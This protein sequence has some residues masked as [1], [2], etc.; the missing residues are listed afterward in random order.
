LAY[1]NARWSVS[2]D[3]HVIRSIVRAKI[4][5][6]KQVKQEHINAF[7]NLENHALSK[8]TADKPFLVYGKK[9]WTFKETYDMSLRYAGWLYETHGIVPGEIVAVDFMNNPSFVFL[10][11]AL[12]S[13]GAVP[14]F[15]NYNLTSE[16]LIHSI[17]TS[18]ARIVLI[19]PEIQ[20]NFHA[21]VLST[22]SSPTFRNNA[23]PVTL[24]TL[25]PQLMSSLPYFPAYR[26]PNSSR[27]NVVPRSP[28]VLIYT[29]G[30]TGLPKPAIVPWDRLIW[31][32]D[33]V[34]Y[35]LGLRPVTSKSKANPPDRYYTCMPLYHNS[36]FSLGFVLCLVRGVTLVLGHKFSTKAFWREVKEGNAT[37]IQYVGE[38]LRYLMTVPAN[39]TGDLDNKVRMAFGNGLRPDVW[40]RFK[41]RFGV[42][43]IAEFYGAT[44]SAGATFNFSSNDLTSG[45]IGRSGLI[46]QFLVNRVSAIVKV[47]W[48]TEMPYRDPKTGFCE[49]V[50]RGDPGE[51][52]YGLNVKDIEDK[53]QGYFGNKEATEKKILRDVLKKGDAYFRSGDT[54]R[55][56]SDGRLWFVDRIGDTFRWKSENVSTAEV[57]ETL[58]RHPKVLEANVYGVEVPGCD[59]KAGCAALLLDG[60]PT[61]EVLESLATFSKNSLPRYA[62]PVFLRVVQSVQATGNNKQ[63]KHVLRKE[64]VDPNL[65]PASERIFY[66][67]PGSDAY[68]PFGKREWD[69]LKAGKV[70]L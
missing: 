33:F 70:K 49:R 52:L 34:A 37:V 55:F 14:A 66:L 53:F 18:T 27:A 23:S 46:N 61:A 21:G 24:V 2:N 57:G 16:P 51:L 69:G 12:W 62:V 8:S 39:P 15:I 4:H 45:A 65:V 59:G 13:L 42:D 5:W 3:W 40:D 26:A 68:E 32:S 20:H 41:A 38:T 30:T 67:K 60:E 11:L 7:Y 56:D 6:N 58:G 44:E 10:T 35:W 50:P 54:V 28:A 29:S 9:T 19:D 47:D 31:G 36:A 64:G 63:Q 25:T 22:L 1:L 17:R 43:T 48:E